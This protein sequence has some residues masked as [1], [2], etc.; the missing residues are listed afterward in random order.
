MARLRQLTMM[1]IKNAAT[2]KK[3]ENDS[4]DTIAGTK[5]KDTEKASP[6]ESEFIMKAVALVKQNVKNSDYSVEQLA[7][8]LCMERTGLY[9]K[10]TS[11]LDKTPSIFIRSIRLEKAAEMLKEGNMTIAEIAEQAGFNSPSYFSKQFQEAYGCK[12]SEYGK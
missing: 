4:E 1:D 6:E 2:D 9:K 8:D 12:P 5:E 11:L 3:S 10:L 7:K